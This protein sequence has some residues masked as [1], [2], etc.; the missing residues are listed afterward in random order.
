MNPSAQPHPPAGPSNEYR[1]FAAG[2]HLGWAVGFPVVAPIVIY[3]MK[4]EQSRF[5]AFH[6]LQAII[7]SILSMAL[8]FLLLF[9]SLTVP[10]ALTLA[11]QDERVMGVTMMWTWLAALVPRGIFLPFSCVAAIKAYRGEE[12][13]LPIA[14]RLARRR[15]AQKA[16]GSG[17]ASCALVLG[18]LLLVGAIVVVA[19]VFIAVRLRHE[20]AAPARDHRIAAPEIPSTA[21][22]ADTAGAG[23]SIGVAECDE[24]LGRMEACFARDPA[25]KAALGSTMQTMRA[26][27]KQAAAGGGKQGLRTACKAS[28]EAMPTQCK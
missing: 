7:W 14:G 2:A 13:E 4:K 9:A 15:D 24:Y 22:P 19:V 5:V 12:Y 25:A 21:A 16:R 27:W 23:D 8:L 20:G 10:L 18:I 26:A 6:A 3:M 17:A 11:A 28:L 1:L